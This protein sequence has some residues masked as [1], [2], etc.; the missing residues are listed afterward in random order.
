MITNFKIFENVNNDEPEIGDY[1]A[2]VVN[3]RY[4]EYNEDMFMNFV[5]KSIGEIIDKRLS[6]GFG[7]NTYYYIVKY[8]NIP[9]IILNYFKFD[10]TVIYAEQ[11]EIVYFSKREEDV[12][13]YFTS[14]K[15][16]L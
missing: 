8:Y 13:L 10:G 2:C 6:N 4:F 5:K 3:E 7:N 16:N 15:Y 14:K 1:V 11:N 9:K 12:E